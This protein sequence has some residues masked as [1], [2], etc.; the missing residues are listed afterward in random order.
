MELDD[1]DLERYARHIRLKEV[2]GTGQ[3]RLLAARILLVGAGGIG[4]PAS[5][6][7]AAAGVGHLG[8]V[9]DDRV[10]LSNL[11][12]Q[13]LYRTDQVGATKTACAATALAGLNPGIRVETH[14]LR[15]DTT[16]ARA[17]VAGHDLVID[18]TDS[19]ASRLA[20]NAACVA[21]RVPLVSAALG[22]FE[23]QLALFS[24]HLPGQPCYRCFVADLAPDGA[25]RSCAEIGILGAVAG[26]VGTWAAL[27]ALRAILD[28][29][30]SLAGRMLLFDARAP[31]TRTVRLRKDPACPVCGG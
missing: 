30:D 18:G 27:E 17:L 26:V 13:I 4:A 31:A 16:N 23:G 15:L 9:D 21:E 3:K 19:F 28:I 5:L 11:Q 12:R 1:T 24:G 14:E 20:V 8:I 10:E 6:Y 7:L 29:G 2:G 25:G 22:A